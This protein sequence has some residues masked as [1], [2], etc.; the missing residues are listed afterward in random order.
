[1]EKNK[2]VPSILLNHSCSSARYSDAA[3]CRF[4]RFPCA[5]AAV[6][7]SLFTYSVGLSRFL[8]G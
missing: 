6:F 4:V 2:G 1:M 3:F 5:L 7:S 8:G